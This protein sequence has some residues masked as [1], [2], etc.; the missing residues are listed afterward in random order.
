MKSLESEMQ[1]L[2][3]LRDYLNELQ[4]AHGSV[5]DYIDT[6]SLPVFGGEEP[7]STRGIFSWDEENFLTDDGP[8][9]RWHIAPR[10][11]WPF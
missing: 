6:T 4:D 8:D 2:K 9:G 10:S 3:Q 7:A 5:D 11:E 1:N